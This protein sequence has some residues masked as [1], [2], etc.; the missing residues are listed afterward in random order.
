MNVSIKRFNASPVQ[1]MLSHRV[2][3]ACHLDAALCIEHH[4][5]DTLK[6]LRHDAFDMHHTTAL[7]SLQSSYRVK[8][9]AVSEYIL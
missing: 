1:F 9:K 7:Y 5:L 2:S 8:S 3:L 4:S 6:A